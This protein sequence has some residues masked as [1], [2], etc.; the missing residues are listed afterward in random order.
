MAVGHGGSV[1][2]DLGAGSGGGTGCV[3]GRDHRFSLS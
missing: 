2:E 1:N 3:D